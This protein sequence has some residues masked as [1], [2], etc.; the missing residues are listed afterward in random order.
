MNISILK[1]YR[2]LKKDT[3]F[4]IEPNKTNFWVGANGTGKT[5]LFSVLLPFLPKSESEWNARSIEKNV[6]SISGFQNIKKVYLSSPKMRQAQMI[7]LDVCFS[8]GVGR[9]WQ[10]EG[11]NS[12]SD[13]IHAATGK[14]ETDSIFMFDEIDGHLDYQFK[15][16]FFLHVLP[17]IKGT[18]IVISHDA[19]FLASEKVFDFTDL[20]F[21]T[22]S[23][24]YLEQQEL[25][26]K[27]MN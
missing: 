19:R 18:K 11:Q 7:D 6:I 20:S 21:K 9:L 13:L 17:K 10:S 1:D 15:V 2:G 14:E 12:I 3:Q 5:T 25:V 22:G 27:K 4:L 16:M 23:R 24:Y 26:L 8:Q